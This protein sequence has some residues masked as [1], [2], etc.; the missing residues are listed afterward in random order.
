MRISLRHP[1]GTFFIITFVISWTIWLTTAVFAP[2]SGLLLSLG[3]FAPTVT[4]LTL[5]AV[6]EGRAGLLAIWRRLLIWRV[7]LGWYLFALGGTAVF[8]LVA[9]GLYRLAGGD[10]E[11]VFNDPAQWYLI[12][13]IF[14]YVLFFSVLGEEIG[15]RGYALPRL[16]VRYGSLLASLIIGVIWSAWHLPLFWLPGNFHQT[17][18]LSLFLLQSVALAVIYTWL[19]NNTQGSLLIAHLFHAASNVTLGV[20]PILPMD[21]SGDLAPL[22]LT[23]ALLWVFTISITI[24]TRIQTPFDHTDMTDSRTWSSG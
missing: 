3:T 20:L 21:T 12:I 15:W 19:H 23:V 18:P 14:F 6:V 5:T 4:A 17:I 1:I 9:L 7:G 16:Q 11:L 8:V 24:L 2:E 10:A 22:W 13:P